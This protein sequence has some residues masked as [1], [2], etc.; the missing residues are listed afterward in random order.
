M[1]L[2]FLKGGRHEALTSPPS[3]RGDRCMNTYLLKRAPLLSLQ[4]HA[5]RLP[6]PPPS[7]CH[8]LDRGRGQCFVL[9]PSCIH[10]ESAAHLVRSGPPARQL[11]R[12]GAEG[13]ESLQTAA[14]STYVTTYLKRYQAPRLGGGFLHSGRGQMGSKLHAFFIPS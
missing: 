14:P 9:C 12:D 7:L 4:P 1:A 10:R 5:L 2:K 3:V 11:R 8:A 6:G 13:S